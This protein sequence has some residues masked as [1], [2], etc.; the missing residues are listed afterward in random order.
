[1]V[2]VVVLGLNRFGERVYEWLVDRDDADVLALLTDPSQYS[3]VEALQP[4]LLVSAG[5][6]HIVPDA[7]LSIPEKG[8][9]NL[10]PSYLPYNRGA[11]PNVWS[12]VESAPAGVSVHYMT[13]DVDAGPI[14]ARQEVPVRPDDDGRSL[15]RRLEDEQFD[16]F[17]ECWP[18]IRDD[19]A[20]E[21]EPEV[22]G[23]YH[24]KSEFTDLFELDHDAETT[25][26]A[27]IDKLRALTYPP[28]DNAYFVED[29]ERYYVELDITP[30][31]EREEGDGIHWNVPTYDDED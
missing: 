18:D 20:T 22:M 31:S 11:N 14:I 9:V 15:Y 27:L 2:S 21:V 23:T 16:L 4:E 13:A 1:M 24:Y 19:S 25:V 29:G 7:V 6:R 8:A 10:H 17:T 30:E 12:I 5:F 26:G 28:Y 3:T